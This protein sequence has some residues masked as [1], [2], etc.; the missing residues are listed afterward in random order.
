VLETL[1]RYKIA[2]ENCPAGI[3]ED[4]AS[5]LSA[6]YMFEMAEVVGR[7]MEHTPIYMST[8]LTLGG[9]TV[10]IAME[11]RDRLK[12]VSVGSM[13]SFGASTPLTISGA[14]ALVLAENLGGAI[15][16]NALTDLPAYFGASVI[17]FDF[18]SLNISYGSPE[19]LIFDLLSI[20]FN[21]KLRGGKPEV[22]S[23]C[24][25]TWAKRP[26]AQAAFEKGSQITAGAMLG[27]KHFVGLGALSM[28]EIF[29]PI[30]LVL[31]VEMMHHVGRMVKGSAVEHMPENIVEMIQQ[32]IDRSFLES[33]LTLDNHS[34]FIWY[35][36]LFTRDSL[37]KWQ[38]LKERDALDEAN[39]IVSKLWHAEPKYE[40]DKEQKKEIDSIYSKACA[41]VYPI[42]VPE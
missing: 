6:K 11:F 23:V 2:I 15:L 22:S 18:H 24:I 5:F 37:S 27:A 17:P 29:C 28:D 38:H 30:Q 3:E 34:D 36:K 26:G 10:K 42:S 14:F 41:E 25:H 39:Q 20:E 1:A 9:D 4:P 32:N 33:D 19:K 8:P 21:A 35:P 13:P 40:L 7:K 12:S 16:V 31:D